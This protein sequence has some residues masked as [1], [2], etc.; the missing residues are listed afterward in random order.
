M[1]TETGR[2]KFRI[3]NIVAE[4]IRLGR[5]RLKVE[6]LL[7]WAENGKLSVY[8]G[9]PVTRGDKEKGQGSFVRIRRCDLMGA[10]LE[11]TTL[12]EVEYGE[13]DLRYNAD[14]K[15]VW[16]PGDTIVKVDLGEV[17]PLDCVVFWMTWRGWVSFMIRC[18]PR[19]PTARMHKMNQPPSLFC[20][21]KP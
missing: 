18:L 21:Q 17:R 7:S 15:S 14:D 9:L 20:P 5:K 4:G 2:N 1:E 8:V 19:G 6:D 3:G 13:F 11:P 16:T 12:I 10:T